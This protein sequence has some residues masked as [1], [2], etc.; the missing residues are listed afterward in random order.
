MQVSRLLAEKDPTFIK[1]WDQCERKF[2]S[3][4][5][6]FRDSEDL[7]THTGAPGNDD[8]IRELMRPLMKNNLTVK[9]P[10]AVAI[11]SSSSWVRHEGDCEIDD[12][13]P[14][15]QASTLL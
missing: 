11:G 10:V 7:R 6:S 5:A 12:P 14:I 15:I 2:K 9:P 1:T 4:E 3:L 8:P 13:T